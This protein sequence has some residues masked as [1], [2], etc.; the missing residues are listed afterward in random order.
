MSQRYPPEVHAFIRENVVGRTA[1]ELAAMTN[2]AFG[3]NFTKDTMRAYWKNH[4]LRSGTPHG[5]PKGHPS[6]TF[7]ASVGDFI[8]ANY[9]GTGHAEMAAMLKEKFGLDYKPSQIK[10]F[11]GNHKLNSGRTGHFQKGHVPPNKGKKGYC[12]P[13][14]EKTHFKKGHTPA[15]TMP[16]GTILTKADGYVWKKIGEG[17]FDWKQLHLLLW[18]EA[19]GPVPDGYVIIFK[20][21]DRQH[22]VLDN[23]VMVTRGE[24]AV[25]NK[26]GLRPESPE[27]VDS[28]IL[29]AKIKIAANKR[30]KEVQP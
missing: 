23:L 28:A 13:G 8:R 11:Y 12:A 7:P 9:K 24:H 17:R 6:D 4:R 22:C 27:Y 3:T 1:A 29:I 10:G 18:E 20:D 21:G 16:I 15:N 2:S 25:M 26:H 30:K 5:L 19:H 14:C